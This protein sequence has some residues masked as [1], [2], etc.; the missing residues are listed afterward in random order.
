MRDWVSHLLWD[1]ILHINATRWDEAGRWNEI[2]SYAQAHGLMHA[3]EM[4]GHNEQE[5]N[6]SKQLWIQ[7][8]K[9]RPVIDEIQESQILSLEHWDGRISNKIVLFKMI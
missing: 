8:D 9:F 7:N 1:E 4:A 3:L 2:V 5:A 6:N